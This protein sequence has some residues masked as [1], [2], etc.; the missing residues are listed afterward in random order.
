MS[1]EEQ[2]ENHGTVASHQLLLVTYLDTKPSCLST[3]R[4]SLC[5]AVEGDQKL[6]NR[7]HR[8]LMLTPE[9]FVAANHWERRCCGSDGVQSMY[10][11]EMINQ[12]DVP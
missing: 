8:V 4:K 9:V 11:D 6:Q 10:A 2:G 5:A 1:P 12:D 7:C 3:V